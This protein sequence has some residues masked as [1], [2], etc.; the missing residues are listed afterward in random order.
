MGSFLQSL[1]GISVPNIGG[2]YLSYREGYAMG[3]V[4][5]KGALRPGTITFEVVDSVEEAMFV[6]SACSGSAADV[7]NIAID[8]KERTIGKPTIGARTVG[9]RSAFCK[10]PPELIDN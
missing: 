2:A 7:E 6:I 3:G 5:F 1:A 10:L 4:Q 9:S 8:G